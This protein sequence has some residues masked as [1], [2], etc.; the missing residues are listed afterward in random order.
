[1]AE[2][3]LLRK[4]FGPETKEVT[5]NGEGNVIMSLMTAL[6]SNVFQMIE[7]RRIIW[8]RNAS[9]MWDRTVLYRA[10]IWKPKEKRPL[11][12][13]RYRW[14]NNTKIHTIGPCSQ[15]DSR[16]GEGASFY[17]SDDEHSV[18]KNAENFLT[19]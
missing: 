19:S 18:S 5:G 13:P 2:C 8:V 17:G 10:L 12:K 9:L 6:S 16:Y 1:M 15:F 7:S 4:L 14:E 11:W 3:R